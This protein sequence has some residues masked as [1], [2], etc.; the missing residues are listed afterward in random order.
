MAD[1][2][3]LRRNLLYV[4]QVVDLKI[5]VVVALTMTDLAKKRGIKVDTDSLAREMG[6]PVVVVNART[7]KGVDQLKSTIALSLNNNTPRQDFYPVF[8]CFKFNDHVRGTFSVPSLLDTLFC[9]YYKNLK[10]FY[11]IKDLKSNNGF[12]IRKE[13]YFHFHS[14]FVLTSA[15][16]KNSTSA[17]DEN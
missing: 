9:F 2:S 17:L 7:G 8:Y 4:S 1:A 13:R 16:V 14:T 10:Y 12:N 5:P 15:I 3:N 11:F 6:V